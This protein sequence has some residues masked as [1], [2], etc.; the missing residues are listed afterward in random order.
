M[1]AL[2]FGVLALTALLVP[3]PATGFSMRWQ[4]LAREAKNLGH[5]VLFGLLALMWASRL[6]RPVAGRESLRLIV[7]LGAAGGAIELIQ[8]L[9]GRSASIQDFMGNILGACCGVSVHH[10]SATPPGIPR[11]RW[12][13]AGAATAALLALAPLMWAGMAYW[14]RAQSLPVIWQAD[15]GWLHYF[16]RWNDGRYPGLQLREVPA[17]WRG[18]RELLVTVR[19]RT[20]Q[21]IPFHVRVEDIH[22]NQR[23]PD[24]HN[25]NFVAAPSTDETARIPIETI[26]MAPR[27]RE[28]DLGSMSGLVVFEIS[29][30]GKR[31]LEPVSIQL[32]R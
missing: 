3:L 16:A 2:L 23:Y 1:A 4:A 29:D 9:T 26:R 25:G 7:A 30:D 28:M 31:M 32:L 6:T 24:R 14:Q 10:W 11:R 5:P 17:D 27:G 15:S 19:N 12:H 21:P 8:I 22:H 18:Y 20:N 13:M